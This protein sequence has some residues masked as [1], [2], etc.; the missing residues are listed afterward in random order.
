MLIDLKVCNHFRLINGAILTNILQ[1]ESMQPMFSFTL[2]NQ[3]ASRL[4]PW[5]RLTTNKPRTNRRTIRIL[6]TIIMQMVPLQP[7]P[8]GPVSTWRRPGS[9]T[10][11]KWSNEPNL[12]PATP[13][14]PCPP[15]RSATSSCRR[16]ISPRQT[17]CSILLY[18]VIV[19]LLLATIFF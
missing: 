18:S 5:F 19:F 15:T 11:T 1:M 10:G 8:P 14:P 13:G 7:L 4:H 9:A 2:R 3:K 6:D 12:V 16:S 17:I